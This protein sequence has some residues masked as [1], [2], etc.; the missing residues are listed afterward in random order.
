MVFPFSPGP[1]LPVGLAMAN[2]SPV[3]DGDALAGNRSG[4][5]FVLDMTAGI[6]VNDDAGAAGRA[7]GANNALSMDATA[8]AN[9]TLAR[10]FSGKTDTGR[11]GQADD[12]NQYHLNIFHF[13]LLLFDEVMVQRCTVMEGFSMF[14]VTGVTIER[15]NYIVLPLFSVDNLRKNTKAIP[16]RMKNSDFTNVIGV[17]SKQ[18]RISG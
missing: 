7:A 10:Y 8:A 16:M 3:T 9:I 1:A 14:Y 4:A 17:I 15:S 11:Q 6:L 13:R 2:R 18:I 5:A 12:D